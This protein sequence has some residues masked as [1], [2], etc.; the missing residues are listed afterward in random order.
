MQ[1]GMDLKM[2]KVCLGALN[3]MILITGK[4]LE[5]LEI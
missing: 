2:K 5:G 4:N 3:Y 1:L